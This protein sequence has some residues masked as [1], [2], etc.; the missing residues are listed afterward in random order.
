MSIWKSSDQWEELTQ[1]FSLLRGFS[2]RSHEQTFHFS[3]PESRAPVNMPPHVQVEIDDWFEAH[4]GVRFRQRS[5]FSTGS[6]EIARN[7]A[8]DTGEVRILRPTAD[9]CFCWSPL[10]EDLYGEFLDSPYGESIPM[11]LKRLDFRCDDLASAIRSNNEIMLVCSD[12][13]ATIFRH[14][15]L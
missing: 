4:F 6:L 15:T 9:Y 12:V 14:P 5:I 1:S 8:R 3:S 11:L 2:T 7:Y 13:S 10:C